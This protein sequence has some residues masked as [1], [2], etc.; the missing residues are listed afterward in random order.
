MNCRQILL[1]N[2]FNALLLAAGANASDVL[3]EGKEIHV[4]VGALCQ[5]TL[6][7]MDFKLDGPT[8]FVLEIT[9]EKVNRI[10]PFKKPWPDICHYEIVFPKKWTIFSESPENVWQNV[11]SNARSNF[12]RSLKVGPSRT[13]FVE[14]IMSESFVHSYIYQNT[15]NSYRFVSL[16]AK[17]VIKEVIPGFSYVHLTGTCP[18]PIKG[19]VVKIYLPKEGAYPNEDARNTRRPDLE[20]FS[21]LDFPP[22]VVKTFSDK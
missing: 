9:R 20:K 21:P 3:A 14:N 11:I 17:A 16:Q 1:G 22:E 10:S 12:V 7:D 13:Y 4:C 6:G 5:E 8:P 19:S 15:A 2:L 18:E